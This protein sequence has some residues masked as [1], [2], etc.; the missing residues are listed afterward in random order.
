[1]ARALRWITLA[2]L[3]SLALP[4]QAAEDWID[5]LPTVTA[6]A[7]AVAE[8]LK[9]DTAD[10]RIDMRGV[11]V[12]DDDDLFAVYMVGTLV[13]LRQIILY[14]YQDEES[15]TAEREAK[16]RLAVAA[17]LEAELYIGE[18]VGKRRGYLTTAQKCKDDECYRRW[19]KT[20]IGNVENF[21]EEFFSEAE[22]AVFDLPV[23][24]WLPRTLELYRGYVGRQRQLASCFRPNP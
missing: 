7:H 17:Y 23:I 4:L 8:Q 3:A 11:A 16:L 10:W 22:L 21:K 1:M 2:L 20:G 14:K 18:W 24:N 5:E 15:L 6:V 19:F 9:I 13:M 12:K